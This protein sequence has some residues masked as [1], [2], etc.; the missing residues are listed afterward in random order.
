LIVLANVVVAG[1]FGEVDRM[2]INASILVVCVI[3]FPCV[4]A[5]W[6]D[7]SW[8]R[9]APLLWFRPDEKQLRAWRDWEEGL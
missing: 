6:I 1:P 5:A 9:P 4:M 3:A 8:D 2:I 7:Y